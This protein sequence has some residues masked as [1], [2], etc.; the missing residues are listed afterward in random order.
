IPQVLSEGLRPF[1]VVASVATITILGLLCVRIAQSSVMFGGNTRLPMVAGWDRLLPD[2]FTRL[3]ARYRTPVNSILFVGA[4]TLAMGAVGL[5][6]VGKQ[7]AF[8]LLWNAAGVFYA[9]TY[10][11]LFAIPLFGL[12]SAGVKIPVWL[13]IA[14]FSG[15]L[16]TLLYAVLSVV[17]IVQVESRVMFAVKIGGLIAV[18]NL[19]GLTIF[20][21]AKRK[22]QSE[23]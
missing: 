7:E 11:V 10:L 15:F 23:S 22:N 5:I 21:L 8:Q 16:M 4:A 13:R 14:S 1:G 19:I 3:H 6:G 9:L 20:L 17:P 12:R 18:T 2:W